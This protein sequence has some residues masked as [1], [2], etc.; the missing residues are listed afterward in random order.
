ML[1]V[2]NHASHAGWNSW[3]C[4]ESNILST[5]R[6]ATCCSGSTDLTNIPPIPPGVEFKLAGVAVALIRVRV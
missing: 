2:Q 5:E 3:H 4:I 1:I 6:L